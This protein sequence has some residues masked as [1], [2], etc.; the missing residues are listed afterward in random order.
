MA[1][2]ELGNIQGLG[3]FNPTGAGLTDTTTKLSSFISTILNVI[4]V[5]VGLFFIV[6]F[7]TAGLQFIT[8]GADE[9]KLNQARDKMTNAVIGLI[10]TVAAYAITGLVGSIF[11]FDILN[12]ADTLGLP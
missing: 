7:A 4:T 3:S 2:Y 5:G 6:Y 11:G 1:K 12:P 8:S 10:I 9:N